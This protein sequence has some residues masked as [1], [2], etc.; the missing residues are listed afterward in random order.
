MGRLGTIDRYAGFTRSADIS[1]LVIDRGLRQATGL[2]SVVWATGFQPV[3]PWLQVP[4]LDSTGHLRHHRGVTDAPGLYS[5]GLRFQH[6]RNATLIDGAR[7]DA[8][9][10]AEQ[11]AVRL[12]Q[13]SSNL[14]K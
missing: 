11:I 1:P 4:V 5:I 12:R 10:L 14:T 7:H 9:Y 13:R 3:Y 8:A 6:R 2:S